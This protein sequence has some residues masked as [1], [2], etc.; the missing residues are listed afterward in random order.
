MAG[1]TAAGNIEGFVYNS[2]N[3]VYQT[4]LSFTSQNMG[5]KSLTVSTRFSSSVCWWSLPSVW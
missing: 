1:N 3:A 2:M 4:S 5:A